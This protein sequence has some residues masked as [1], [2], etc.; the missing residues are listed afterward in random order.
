MPYAIFNS[1]NPMPRPFY[2]LP[3][4][5]NKIPFSLLFKA[6]MHGNR[7]GG[8]EK[9]KLLKKITG[10]AHV[11]HMSS[12][13]SA[14]WLILK[15]LSKLNP[16]KRKVI[17]PAYTCPAVA[18]AVLKT[19]LQPVLCDVNLDDFGYCA[20]D[21]ERTVDEGVLAVIVAHL[22]GFPANIDQ[23]T[24]MCRE[25][26]VY[27]VE[28]AA[29]AFG[30]ELPSTGTRLG[31]IGDAGFFSFGRGKPL[32]VIHGGLVVTK[33]ETV[34]K[35][36][37]EI[38]ENLNS[39]SNL[40]N[41]KYFSQV[42]F[43]DVLSSPY[44]Y[45]MPQKIPSMHLGETIFEPHFPLNKGLKSSGSIVEGLLDSLENRMKDRMAR[46]E[47]YSKSLPDTQ[48]IKKPLHTAYPF[49]RY[50]LMVDDKALR[51]DIMNGLNSA[52]ISGALF[53]PCP[54]NEIPGLHDVL[55]DSRTYPNAKRLS[56][57][58]ITLPVHEGV[59]LRDRNNIKSVIEKAL[60]I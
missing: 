49:H 32:S 53:Y 2:S 22:F 17:I 51:N 24:P 5:G 45:W 38:Y 47:W 52:G 1:I 18:S 10:N 21:L 35:K 50:P 56:D 34:Y 25:H 12:G 55:Q 33:S 27:L 16:K 14:L 59:T 48:M 44:L 36:G 28:D 7:N 41:I 58:L 40:G 20:D 6:M 39:P 3:P 30:N 23:V 57:T 19:G 29:Q 9:S 37:L 60:A 46:S 8:L 11:L 42:G 26:D 54:L 4:A 31:T 15:T 13:R 43:Y